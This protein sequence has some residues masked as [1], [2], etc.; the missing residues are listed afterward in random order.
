MIKVT[1]IA[2]GFDRDVQADMR[3]QAAQRPVS[4][5]VPAS[6]AAVPSAGRGAT[7]HGPAG[8]PR[9]PR[10]K[11]RRCS[12][13]APADQRFPND[14]PVVLA[15]PR[16]DGAAR[17]YGQ[18]VGHADVSAQGAIAEYSWRRLIP[19]LARPYDLRF[20]RKRLHE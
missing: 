10:A 6:F 14:V 9:R 8:E 7:G 3:A 2:T 4:A 18:R 13:V 16:A 17:G 11:R 5:Q 20:S 1:V 12:R 15:D 19:G